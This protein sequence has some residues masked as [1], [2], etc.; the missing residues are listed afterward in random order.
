M[1]L[2][3]YQLAFIAV[4]ICFSKA[5]HPKHEHLAKTSGHHMHDLI[6]QIYSLGQDFIDEAH[7]VEQ[8]HNYASNNFNHKQ[9]D[10]TGKK[11]S[12]IKKAQN[13]ASNTLV[14]KEQ[15][16]QK[17]HHHLEKT[18]EQLES[19]I[20]MLKEGNQR[21]TNALNGIPAHTKTQVTK[22]AKVKKKDKNHNTIQFSN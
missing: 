6:E 3:I 19:A 11:R 4:I 9:K 12:L 22:P 18:K 5:L 21:T 8:M 13:E 15:Q 10:H 16:I 7:K 14:R 2:C 20:R 17:T 1:K